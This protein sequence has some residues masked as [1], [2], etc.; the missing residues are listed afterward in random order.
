VDTSSV[1]EGEAFPS[2]KPPIRVIAFSDLVTLNK[3]KKKK[4]EKKRKV[5]ERK[6]KK[7]KKE[8]RSIC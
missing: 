4:K 2:V 1:N 7:G 6:K 5:K 8:N 3:R